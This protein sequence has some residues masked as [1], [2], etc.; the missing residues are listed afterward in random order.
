MK[1][2]TTWI[3][4]AQREEVVLVWKLV[5]HT[6][7]SATKSA[8]GAE[9]IH[10]SEMGNFVQ[11]K[12]AEIIHGP[13]VQPHNGCIGVFHNRPA[14]FV[15]NSPHDAVLVAFQTYCVE[16]YNSERAEETTTPVL[17][18]FSRAACSINLR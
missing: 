4:N 10:P 17:V 5:S 6:I 13:L 2:G 7:Q 12:V 15:R 14:K 16:R 8:L 11:A 18:L 3:G 1:Q 9:L